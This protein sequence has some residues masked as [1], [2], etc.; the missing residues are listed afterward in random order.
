MS[1][2]NEWIDENHLGVRYGLKGKIIHH[3]KSKFQDIII[4]ET[5]RYGNALLLNNCW[6]AAEKL[7]K[8]YHECLVHPALCGAKEISNVLIIGGGDGGTAREC[9]RYSKVERLDIV[10]IDSRVIELAQQFLPK[11]GGTAWNDPRLNVHIEDGVGWVKKAQELFY[12]III[13]D[14]SDPD[15]PAEGLFNKSFFD[16]CKHILKPG[17]IFATQSESPEA[18]KEIHIE[19]IKIMREIFAYVDPLYGCVPMYPSGWWSWTFAAMD[20]PRYLT[21]KSERSS[22]II[23]QCKIWS[24]RWQQGGFNAIPAFI[25]RELA[26]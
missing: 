6:M 25:E 19:T 26:S 18:F 13:V 24:P 20:S 10:E 21:P 5:E 16:R 23:D 17:G 2:S 3:E 11:I 4:V 12:D 22:N 15:G 7:E 14:G 1:Q 8:H 9:L